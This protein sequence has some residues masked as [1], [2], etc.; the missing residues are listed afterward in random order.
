MF[1]KLR[2]QFIGIATIAVVVMLLS[3][4]GVLNASRFASTDSQI[5]RVLTLLSRNGGVFPGEEEVEQNLGRSVSKDSILQYRYFS[6]TVDW[7]GNIEIVSKDNIANLGE[8]EI[9]HYIGQIYVSRRFS[10]TF[11]TE[12]GQI[13]SFLVTALE[14]GGGSLVVVLDSTVYYNYRNE[15]MNTSV[16][17]FCG[18]LIFFI[19]VFFVFSGRV[20]APFV[21]NYQNQKRFITN[22]SHELKTPL[23]I[24]SANNELEEMVSG[25][26]EWTQSTKD[27]IQRMT[28]LI[29]RLV[30]LS[31][32]EEQG[33]VQLSDV[34][35][36]QVAKKA[37]GDFKNLVQKEGK[38]FSLDIVP[39]IHIQGDEK[40]LFELVSLLVD[41]A[42][43]YCDQKGIVRIRL[44]RTGAAFKKIRLEVSNSYSQGQGVDYSRF[45]DRFYREDQSHNSKK[46]G[47][48]IGLSIAQNIVKKH[49]GRISVQY[50][51][52][53][54]TF[55]I[56]F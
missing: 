40:A 7:N 5:D 53:V 2:L 26:N 6:A 45:F 37:G 12:E 8:E 55:C 41:N 18:N 43:K 28:E 9:L 35:F 14:G 4:I 54:I 47:Y 39:D 15:L 22:A 24:I 25:E 42:N 29:N 36:S 13:F 32:L 52:P 20:I 56:V 3:I 46:N 1:T 10:G 27:Q 34:D 49:R 50:K 16:V 33:D 31:R 38:E 17:L 23:A 44:Q 30:V 21:E 51:K 11:Q 48:G 19:T